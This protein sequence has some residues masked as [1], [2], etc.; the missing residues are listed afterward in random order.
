MVVPDLRGLSLSE[1]LKRLKPYGLKVKV[2][3]SGI[4]TAQV[5]ESGELLPAHD[6]IELTLERPL[7]LS[8]PPSG[9][10]ILNEDLTSLE[11]L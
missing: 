5:P 8:H 3:G 9:A 7:V 6:Q 10:V 11:S 2:T 1:A 4:I